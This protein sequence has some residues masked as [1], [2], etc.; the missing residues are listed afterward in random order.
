MDSSTPAVSTVFDFSLTRIKQS[1]IRVLDRHK[2]ASWSVLAFVYLSVALFIN[3]P[4]IGQNFPDA[5]QSVTINF[6]NLATNTIVTNQY[7]QVKFSAA[8]FSAGSGGPF[9]V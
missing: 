2:R 4:V 7:E 6:D 9:G 8:G 1:R 5:A 3:S